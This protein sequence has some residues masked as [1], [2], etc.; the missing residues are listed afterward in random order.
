MGRTACT[1]L[2][3]LYKGALYFYLYLVPVVNQLSSTNGKVK[4]FVRKPCFHV[5]FY[6]FYPQN[7]LIPPEICYNA[8]L[9]DL[10][11]NVSTIV[12]TQQFRSPV[13]PLSLFVGN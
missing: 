8:S 1:E 9:Q 2:Q 4:M 12:S 10:K 6:K 11:M 5:V 13:M 3:C 7:G